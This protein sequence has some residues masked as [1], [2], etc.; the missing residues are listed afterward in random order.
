MP[1]Q[2]QQKQ[3]DGSPRLQASPGDMVALRY[4]ENGHV[5][6]PDIVKGKPAPSRGHVYIYGTTQPSQDEKVLDVKQWNADGTG[7]NKKGKLLGVQDYD[8]GQCY[9]INGGP[10]SAARQKQFQH[11]ADTL[12]GQ[13][14]WCQ[15]DIKIPNDAPVGKPY[16][17]YW[18]WDWSTLPNADPGL[19]N[20]KAELYS[21]CMDIDIKASNSGARKQAVQFAQGQDLNQAAIGK[22]VAA[23]N[24]GNPQGQPAATSSVPVQLST[25][26]APQQPSAAAA[27]PAEKTV[28]VTV[29]APTS[30]VQSTSTTLM[31]V[32]SS[33][34]TVVAS[35][36]PAAA[37]GIPTISLPNFS[38]TASPVAS[39]KPSGNGYRFARRGGQH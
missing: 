9:Q 25:S 30:P 15:N 35:N 18:L 34:L 27:Q 26:A 8:D 21:T 31:T 39:S 11:K 23:L 14:L 20:G 3:S 24:A 22:Y 1:S 36:S 2:Q 7:G 32:P 12:M 6:L 38:G 10:I 28:T 37:A 17:V 29:T 19:P 16:T 13:D 5:T 33:T 4:Q